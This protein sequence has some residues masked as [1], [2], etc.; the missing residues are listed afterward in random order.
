MDTSERHVQ[1]EPT[2]DAA[3]GV[4]RVFS[5][6]DISTIEITP[7][8]VVA[9]VRDAYRALA[10]G[11]SDNPRKLTVKPADGHSIAYAMLARDG[12]RDVVAVKTSY[13]HDPGHDRGT[14]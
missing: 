6:S 1:A 8:E 3:G 10:D 5:K 4:L 13:K 14:Q 12:V 2:A 7:A 9:V 11:H